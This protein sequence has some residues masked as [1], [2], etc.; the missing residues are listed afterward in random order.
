MLEVHKR[1][2]ASVVC[3]FLGSKGLHAYYQNTYTCLLLGVV[4]GDFVSE[5]VQ[6]EPR[7]V[8]RSGFEEWF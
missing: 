8:L 6:N 1:L 2:L 3:L 4:S 5:G 7:H